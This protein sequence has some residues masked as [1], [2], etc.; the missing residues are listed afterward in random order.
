MYRSQAR[1]CARAIGSAGD[2]AGSKLEKAEKLGVE[3][4]DFDAF[5]E[6]LGEH[7]GSLDGNG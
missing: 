5:L 4:L 1:I 6:R 2:K 3:V 7:G